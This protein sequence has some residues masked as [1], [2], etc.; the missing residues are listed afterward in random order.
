M[1]FIFGCINLFIFVLNARGCLRLFLLVLGCPICFS[2]FQV[3]SIVVGG[4]KLKKSC[5]VFGLLL[6][7]LVVVR[8]F[9]RFKFVLAC[10]VSSS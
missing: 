4:G 7:L 1:F 10:F 3:D 6:L 9:G 8:C 2:L 5:F